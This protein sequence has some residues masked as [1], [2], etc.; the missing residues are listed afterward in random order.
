[1]KCV[2]L[3]EKMG[4]GNKRRKVTKRIDDLVEN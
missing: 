3:V 4:M 2:G 1:M